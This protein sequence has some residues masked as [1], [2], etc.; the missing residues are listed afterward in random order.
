M[1]ATTSMK[2]KSLGLLVGSGGAAAVIVWQ[3]YGTAAA[4]VVTMVIAIV[5]I[6]RS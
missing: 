4:V 1:S 5:H 6:C 3:L 2:E